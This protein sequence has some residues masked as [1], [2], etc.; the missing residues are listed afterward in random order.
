MGPSF[1][2]WFPYSTVAED[3]Q[4]SLLPEQPLLALRHPDLLV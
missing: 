2:C 3:P 4:A 1:T